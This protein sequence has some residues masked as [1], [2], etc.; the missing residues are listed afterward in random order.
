M[1]VEKM[2]EL[3]EYNAWADR[4]ALEATAALTAEQFV[5]PLG[6]SFGSVRETLTHIC[7][8]EWIW[9]E[10]FLGRSPASF[11]AKDRFADLQALRA[12]WLEQEQ[13]LLKFVSGLTAEDLE[14]EFAYTTV[15]YG[16]ARNPLWQSLTHVANHGTYH[17]GQV[18]TMLRQLGAKPLGTDMIYFYRE[19]STAAQA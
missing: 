17:R 10:R 16:E 3:Y 9:L 15:S 6:S 11:P 13:G 7:D 5:K 18:A 19:R 14:R 4:R 2:R 8:A 1:A 12:H